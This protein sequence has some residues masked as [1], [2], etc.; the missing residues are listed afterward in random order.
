[1]S[2]RVKTAAT[3]SNGIEKEASRGE[4]Q[5]KEVVLGA[6]GK[7]LSTRFALVKKMGVCNFWAHCCCFSMVKRLKKTK[8]NKAKVAE[9][10]DDF[11]V[12]HFRTA[13]HNACM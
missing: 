7:A 10:G 6:D 5:P 1:M 11:K 3:T 2:D 12:F 4:K 8:E 13:S 9:K